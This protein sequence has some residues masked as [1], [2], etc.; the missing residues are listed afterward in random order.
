MIAY[1]QYFLDFLKARSIKSNMKS[2]NLIFNSVNMKKNH[3]H[4]SIYYHILNLLTLYPD[5]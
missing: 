2:D 4:M 3:F 1:F 5:T